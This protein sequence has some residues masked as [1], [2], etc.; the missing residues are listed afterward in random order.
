MAAEAKAQVWL[1]KVSDGDGCSIV[2]EGGRVRQ[3][4][5]A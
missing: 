5:A 1:E 3:E 4:D 2:I